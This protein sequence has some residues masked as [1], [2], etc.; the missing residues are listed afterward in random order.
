MVNITINEEKYEAKQIYYDTKINE[1]EDILMKMQISDSDD[2]FELLDRY[3]EVIHI[4]SGISLEELEKGDVNDLQTVIGVLSALEE[5]KIEVKN[6]IIINDK[7]F[8]TDRIYDKN[9]IR[10]N[11]GQYKYIAGE[12]SKNQK[13][14]KYI[15]QIAASYFHNDEVSLEDKV[16]LFREHMNTIDVIPFILKTIN[17]ISFQTQIMQKQNELLNANV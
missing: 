16:K 2:I 5:D 8:K 7:V 1:F 11:R 12:M 15:A 10:M 17:I 9:N 13:N 14:G 4:L 3:V 6:E